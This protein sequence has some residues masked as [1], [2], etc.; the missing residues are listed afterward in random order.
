MGLTG[1]H[2]PDVIALL[3]KDQYKLINTNDKRSILVTGGAGSGKTT[4]ALH[5]IGSLCYKHKYAPSLILVVVPERG[6]VRLSRKL[7]KNLGL[8]SVK[9]TTNSDWIKKEAKR[10]FKNIPKKE[11]M[12]TPTGVSILKKHKS[13]LT[14]LDRFIKKKQDEVVYKLF[15]SK[16]MKDLKLAFLNLDTLPL[17]PRLQNLKQNYKKIGPSEKIILD[18][19]IENQKNLYQDCLELFTSKELL[20]EL[21]VLSGG[22]ITQRMIDETLAHTIYQMKDPMELEDD[23]TDR[24]IDGQTLAFNTKDELAA[25]LDNE[26]Y[27]ILMMLN[28]LKTGQ[29]STDDG[30]IKKFSHIVLDEAQE[31]SPVDLEFFKNILHVDGNFTISGDSAQQIDET[32]SF[33]GWPMVLESLSIDDA[34]TKELEVAYRCPQSIITFAHQVLGPIAPPVMPK[35]QKSGQAIMYTTALHRAHASM[36]LNKELLDLMIREPSASV[37]LICNKLETAVNFYYELKNIPQVRLVE[38]GEFSFKAG[39]D[40]STVDQIKGLEFDYVIIPDVDA[41]NYPLVDRARKRLHISA[42][43]AIFQLWIISSS[44]NSKLLEQVDMETMAY[45]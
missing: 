13:L 4:V 24:T 41:I 16:K 11:S 20:Q 42:T 10:L 35:A 30:N 44:E 3:D 12:N 17:I 33:Y 29:F 18:A 43:R 31:L 7:L 37:A 5:R 34:D 36:I 45:A 25:T 23:Y 9:V 26:D 40:I 21:I 14:I 2:Q 8:S 1:M 39:I 27:A 38:D 6:L 28:K 32:I 19:E 15:S 22:V